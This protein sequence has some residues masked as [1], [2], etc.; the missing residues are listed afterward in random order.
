MYCVCWLIVAPDRSEIIFNFKRKSIGKFHRKT[1]NITHQQNVNNNKKENCL[2][3]A[4]EN[5]HNFEKVFEKI[6]LKWKWKARPLAL[7]RPTSTYE[8]GKERDVFPSQGTQFK[9]RRQYDE[10]VKLR[11]RRRRRRWQRIRLL[12][13]FYAYKYK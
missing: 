5:I 13:W 4:N 2:E 7:C 8:R 3:W 10:Y 6:Y 1:T 11:R 9:R 12:T